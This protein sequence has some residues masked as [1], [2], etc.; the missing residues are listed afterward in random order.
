MPGGERGKRVD[1]LTPGSVFGEMAVLD[2]KPRAAGIVA[3]TEAAGYCI[4]A[5]DF[6]ALKREHPQIALKI[7]SNLCLIMSGR[8]RTANRM[9]AELE[10]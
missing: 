1:T 2:E 8:V 3:A 7:L 5:E 9:I 6:A 4:K 10:G